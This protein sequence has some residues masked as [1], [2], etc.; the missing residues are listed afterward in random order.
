MKFIKK[1]EYVHG[2]YRGFLNGFLATSLMGTREEVK[3]QLDY[4]ESILNRYDENIINDLF[5]ISNKRITQFLTNPDDL[6][7]ILDLKQDPNKRRDFF[8]NMKKN[9]GE[10]V[11]FEMFFDY[12]QYFL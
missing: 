7:H 4:I 1:I 2:S 5:R 8:N 10:N 11:S 9:I 6:I 12:N 3:E